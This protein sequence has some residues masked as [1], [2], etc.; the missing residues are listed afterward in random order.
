MQTAVPDWFDN[1]DITDWADVPP[2][3]LLSKRREHADRHAA[4][5]AF[6]YSRAT[7]SFLYDE[8]GFRSTAAAPVRDA[9]PLQTIY[10]VRLQRTEAERQSSEVYDVHT[11]EQARLKHRPLDLPSDATATAFTWFQRRGKLIDFIAN[12]DSG[13]V[14]KGDVWTFPL[15][16]PPGWMMA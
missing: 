8:I 15:S 7:G 9:V 2:E 1:V 13:A 11:A 12:Q 3:E 14:R 6:K 10:R 16:A 5:R 4:A